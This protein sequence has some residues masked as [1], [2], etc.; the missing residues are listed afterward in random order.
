MNKILLI[1]TVGCE[2]CRI[3][4]NS[5][6]TA[7]QKANADINFTVKE[8]TELNK[9]FIQKA[10][11]TDF[12]TT[13]FYKDDRIVFKATGSVPSIIVSRWITVQFE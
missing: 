5:I 10:K 11:I 12:P 9:S 3:M 4:K 1:T 6:E 8:S 7:L 13:L 2:G